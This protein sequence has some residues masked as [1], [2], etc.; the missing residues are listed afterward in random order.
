MGTSP[1]NPSATTSDISKPFELKPLQPSKPLQFPVAPP[2]SVRPASQLSQQLPRPS[3]TSPQES[4][5]TPK[6]SPPPPLKS[7]S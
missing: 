4:Q 3:N 1:V 7:D 5:S 6:G 2:N